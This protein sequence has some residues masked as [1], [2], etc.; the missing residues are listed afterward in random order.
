MRVLLAPMEGV[1]DPLV[2]DLLTSINDY[3][4]CITEFIRVVDSLL[5]TKVFYR[6]CPELLTQSCTN[7]GTPVRVQLL[8]QNPQWLA[9]NAFRAVSL[10]S[11]GVDL[12]CGC[13]SKTV[14]GSG[15]GASLLKQPDMIYQATK[16]M[17][18]A[19]PSNLPISVKV[20]LGWDSSTYSHEI[21]DAVVQGG[22]TEITIHGRTKE[23][24][25]RAEKIDWQAIGDI[26]Q[27]IAIPVIANGEIWNREDA[28]S[29][30]AITGCD[31]VMLGRG[32][33]NTPNLSRVVKGIEP[34]MSW[35][36][37]I[38]LLK[39]YIRLEKQG[40]TT[41]YHASRIKQ[42]LGYLRK[43][44]LEADELFRQIRTL[45]TSPEIALAIEAL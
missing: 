17:R 45:K 12:N 13:P 7:S 2:R 10:G 43:E 38:L 1:L 6:L 39:R 21:A 11:W 8:G 23:D 29:C 15:G 32:A 31:A 20:R 33:M 24:G 3:D 36:D 9:E 30:L 16:A 19:V 34:K 44:Y 5:P 41:I 37:V 26:R 40:D 18:D 28:L 42:W 4:L 14:N 22:A 27:K 25:Y 35:Q